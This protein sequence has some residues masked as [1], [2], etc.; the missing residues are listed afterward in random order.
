MKKLLLGCIILT[1][2]LLQTAYAEKAVE[3]NTLS[4]SVKYNSAIFDTLYLQGDATF[5][6]GDSFGL[7]VGANNLNL[8][9]ADETEN[10]QNLRVGGFFRNPKHGRVEVA[11]QQLFINGENDG[12]YSITGEYYF[13]NWT[14][15]AYVMSDEL[16]EL[17][18]LNIYTNIYITDNI[19]VE[20]DLL[21]ASDNSVIS[22]TLNFQAPDYIGNEWQF[23][24]SYGEGFWDNDNQWGIGVKYTPDFNNT[25]KRFY[26]NYSTNVK[27][28]SFL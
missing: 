15:G 19:R 28:F 3:E 12:L 7:S 11:Y 18:D 1:P 4:Y 9:F 16:S 6:L 24:L 23:S 21:D 25:L 5:A 17:N 26:R 13:D 2:T 8:S 10:M 27:A 14:L 20:I 22:A